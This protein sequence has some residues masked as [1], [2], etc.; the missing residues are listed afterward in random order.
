MPNSKCILVLGL[1]L[2]LEGCAMSPE[3]RAY[4]QRLEQGFA[5][6][7]DIQ[8]FKGPNVE[9]LGLKATA[10]AVSPLRA[11]PL[12][13]ALM[14]AA[15]VGDTGRIKKL[16]A[17]GA[18]VNATDAWGNTPLLR[19]VQS[20][21]VDGVRLLLRKGA[22]V[23]GRDGALSPL[24]AA[25]LLGYDSV[26]KLLIRNGADVNVRDR[27]GQTPLMSAVKLNHPAMVALLLDAGANG[28]VRFR[29]GEN[30]LVLAINQNAYDMLDLLLRRGLN[31]NL[32]DAHG[33]TALY[34]AELQQKPELAQRLLA[35]GADPARAQVKIL[36]SRAYDN[37]EF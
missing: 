36:E 2:L 21:N 17:D 10:N 15:G 30:L 9:R 37:G 32:P 6:P 33:L 25:A 3:Q 23:N 7:D 31:P 5:A 28:A 35:A 14:I 4:R 29:D 12:D 27:N 1:A 16:L 18:R 19:A 26:A 13:Q 34:W 8:Y 20:G 11:T 22:D 24:G